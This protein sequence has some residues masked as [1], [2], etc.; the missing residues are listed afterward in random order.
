MIFAEI[1]IVVVM[2]DMYY[3]CVMLSVVML[4]LLLVMLSIMFYLLKW[5]QH[6]VL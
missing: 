5:V 3:M 4:Y 1:Y 6:V 2:F